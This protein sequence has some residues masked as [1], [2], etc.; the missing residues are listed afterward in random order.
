MLNRYQRTRCRR[1]HWDCALP[2]TSTPA[3]AA[4]TPP[5]SPDASPLRGGVA[6]ARILAVEVS[7]GGKTLLA[8]CVLCTLALLD[9]VLTVSS[10]SLYY[11]PSRGVLYAC[12]GVVVMWGILW[13]LLRAR[14]PI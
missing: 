14:A 10:I 4:A 3:T 11:F 8:L 6:G 2:C 13:L 9:I 5:P 7:I 12:D 1:R